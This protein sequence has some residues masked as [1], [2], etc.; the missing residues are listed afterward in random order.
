VRAQPKNRP[1]RK[2]DKRRREEPLLAP[3]GSGLQKTYYTGVLLGPSGSGKTTFAEQ[4]AHYYVRLGGRAWAID[5]NG[6]WVDS[7][8]VKSLWPSDG[9]A[10]I[11]DLMNASAK[12]P[13]GLIIGDDAD[14]YVGPHP[15][16]PVKIYITSNRHIA[17]DQLWISRRPQG[18]P[19]DLFG[20]MHFVALFP[21]ALMEPGARKYLEETF[22]DEIL[23]AVPMEPFHYL[24]IQR[25]GARWRY[26][27]RKTTARKITTKSDKT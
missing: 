26:S 8:D 23:D 25:E 4:I 20:V 10:G 22:P 17:K 19:K 24:L 3:D 14:R 1:D 27:R 6:A 12:W 11:E 21:G 2:P 7:P 18:I 13:P 9:D 15:T 5:P 16:M